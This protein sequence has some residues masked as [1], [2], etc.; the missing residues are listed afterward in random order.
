MQRF[1]LNKKTIGLAIAAIAV[2]VV[3][4]LMYRSDQPV[5]REP[6]PEWEANIETLDAQHE[7][8]FIQSGDLQLEAELLIPNGGADSK[9]AVIFSGGSGDGLFQDYT[10]GFIETYVQ[11][12]FLPRDMAVLF[13]NKRGMGQSEGNWLHNDFEGRADDLYS[14]VQHLQNHPAIDPD[15]IG[16]IGHSQGGWIVGLTAAQHTDVAFFISLAAPTTPVRQQMIDTYTNDFACQGY[17]GEDLIRRADRQMRLTRLGANV[18]KVI[19][20]G[21]IGFDTEIIDYDPQAALLAVESP[22]LLVYGSNDL[23]VP[24][25]HSRQR[26]EEIFDGD[27]PD[28]LTFAVIDGANHS[29]RLVDDQCVSYEDALEMPQSDELLTV[30]EDWLAMQGY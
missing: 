4:V 5:K 6:S 29:F 3:A 20:V 10:L 15:N 7:K 8:F 13:V 23:L 22:G 24:P 9:A 21:I 19:D 28:H 16:L 26:L 12:V 27:V 18:G 17:E 25:E 30:L 14:A 1:T 2:I 11:D